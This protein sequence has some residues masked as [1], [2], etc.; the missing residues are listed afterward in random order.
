MKDSPIAAMELEDLLA[1]FDAE[2]ENIMAV[3]EEVKEQKKRR[4]KRD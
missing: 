1:V 3:L 4:K 2:D